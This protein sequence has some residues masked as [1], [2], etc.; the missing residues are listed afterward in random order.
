MKHRD[1]QLHSLAG[2][3]V[4][5]ALGPQERE[6]FEQ[7]LAHCDTCSQETREF[8]ETAAR[9]AAAAAEPPPE[10]MKQKA[11][12]TAAVTS[13][14]PPLAPA[15]RRSAR[16]G[17]RHWRP[18]W[19]DPTARPG[20]PRL[21]LLKLRWSQLGGA[22]ALGAAIAAV[23]LFAVLGNNDGNR[24]TRSNTRIAAVLT[25]PDAITL[26]AAVRDGGTSTMVMSP[27]QGQLV[28][29]ASRLAPLPKSKCYMLWLL[30]PAGD[31]PGSRLPAPVDGTT[32]PVVVTGITD[33][34]HLGLSVEP[35][36]GSSRPT[37]AMLINVTL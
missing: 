34:D 33:H 36:H 1:S 14:L 20:R 16:P 23:G 30:G 28:F 3:Y 37:S 15:V 19:P 12:A 10:G 27:A 17:R 18:A 5:D 21:N 26:T 32:G 35:A 9:L 31:I 7:H 4:L 11:L 13:Q 6:R 29:A 25:A 22:I 24:S 2:A 8:R